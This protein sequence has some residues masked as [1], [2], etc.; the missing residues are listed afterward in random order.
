MEFQLAPDWPRSHFSGETSS[1]WQQALFSSPIAVTANTTYIA[2][3]HA[4][5]GHYSDDLGYFV[6]AGIDNSPLHA[7]AD[8]TDGANGVYSY[9]ATSSFPSFGYQSSNYWVD[10]IFT[11]SNGPDTTPPSVTAVN[12]ANAATNVSTATKY[13]GNFQRSNRS[14]YDQRKHVPIVRSG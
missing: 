2:S 1:G 8:G 11:T 9:G 6:S 14:D 7:L 5:N 3:Y 12:P 10:V 4:P 13:F